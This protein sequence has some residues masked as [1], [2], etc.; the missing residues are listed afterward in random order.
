MVYSTPLN[1]VHMVFSW[2]KSDVNHSVYL[3]EFKPFYRGN[4][5]GEIS[6]L[7]H[8]KIEKFLLPSIGVDLWVY[9]W[10]VRRKS[11][12]DTTTRPPVHST[13]KSFVSAES[14]RFLCPRLA[15]SWWCPSSSLLPPLSCHR[16]SILTSRATLSSPGSAFKSAL[17][18]SIFTAVINLAETLLLCG[19]TVPVSDLS[20]RTL[21]H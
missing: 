17:I 12:S 2:Q 6:H 9:G 7:Q 15:P 21:E 16:N 11:Q 5:E 8:L 13:T 10:N 18:F 1:I 14:W 4:R 20:Q 19:H 3:T